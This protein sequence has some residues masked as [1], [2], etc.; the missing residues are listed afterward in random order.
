MRTFSLA[1]LIAT[2]ALG[3]PAQATEHEVKMLNRGSSGEAMVFEPLVVRAAPGD[4]IV[5]TPT[6][7]SHNSVSMKEGIPAGAQPW[8]GKINEK[9]SV[10]VS[11]PGV[12]LYQCSP[13]VSM[14]MIGAVVVGEPKNLDAV[15]SAKFPGAAKKTAEKIF[16][17]IKPGG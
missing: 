9:I 15:K 1:F 14:G 11:E 10:T 7:K 8:S 2:A 16:A 12:Y 4:T 13:H 6:D 17:E 5:F 3:A